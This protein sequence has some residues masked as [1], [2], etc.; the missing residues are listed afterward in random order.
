MSE[1]TDINFE[2]A[3]RDPSIIFPEA[4][5]M[6]AEVLEHAERFR[7]LACERADLLGKVCEQMTGSQEWD[8][9]DLPTLARQQHERADSIDRQL[10]EARNALTEIG[11][12]L[13][14]IAGWSTWGDVVRAARLLR[15]QLPEAEKKAAAADATASHLSH[16]LNESQRERLNAPSVAVVDALN[17][18]V[19]E[20]DLELVR[21][22]KR[23]NRYEARLLDIGALLERETWLTTPRD[24]GLAEKVREALD[25]VR[26]L[27]AELAFTPVTDERPSRA[28]LEVAETLGCEVGEVSARLR[29]LLA[30][31]RDAA[32][33][34]PIVHEI[35]ADYMTR[36][37]TPVVFH[38]E[39]P[40]RLRAEAEGA[41][42][43]LE[44]ARAEVERLQA[45]NAG[46]EALGRAC[47]CH[48]DERL[49]IVE[50][51][52]H[53]RLRL[54][55]G[56]ARRELGAQQRV[57]DSYIMAA[58]NARGALAEVLS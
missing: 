14:G 28:H 53:A 17:A 42:A 13:C 46:F 24:S 20:L 45:I 39:L 15:E 11:N 5:R 33:A 23:A 3:K 29:A 38:A 50:C 49:V 2:R 12:A 9:F 32:K 27:R 54:E 58:C 44:K 26:S 22:R 55:L 6:V 57:L 25:K 43:D 31:E 18:K 48:Y 1:I 10:V 35:A 7:R 56:D 52:D 16:L 8:L 21:Q 36:T 37:R 30:I 51:A 19:R 47:G 41:Q 34:G 4:A 40:K